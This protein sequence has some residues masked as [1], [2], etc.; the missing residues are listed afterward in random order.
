MLPENSDVRYQ[1]KPEELELYL[2]MIPPGHRLE[3][4][5]EVIDFQALLPEIQA[6]YCPDL[7]QPAV[8]P[9]I[10]FKLE[11]MKY[12][13]NLS[14]RS[15]L[16]RACTDVAFRYF[17]LIP[18]NCRLPH[19]TLLCRFRGR[20]GEDGYRRIFHRILK[21]ARQHGLVKD[22]LRLKDATHILANISI[23][24]TLGLVAQLR[25]RLI[26]EIEPLDPEAAEGF[27]ISAEQTRRQTQGQPDAIR[28]Q[29][30]V[31]LVQD[32][33]LFAREFCSQTPLP[34]AQQA[35]LAETLALA[36]KVLYQQAHPQTTHKTRSMV[37]PDAL[38]G[39]HGGY[40][41][42]YVLD[43][44]MDADS[45]L[46][47]AVNVLPAGGNEAESAVELIQQEHEHQGNQIEQLSIDGAGFN[48]RMIRQLEGPQSSVAE[49]SAESSGLGVT[50][51]VP[52][53]KDRSDVK[54]PASEFTPSADAQHVT[55]P[56]GAQSQYRQKDGDGVIY[57]FAAST[58]E[59]CPLRALCVS[60]FGKTPF[61]RSVRK[62]DYEAEYARVRERAQTEEFE[63]IRSRH[64]AIERKLNECAN[65]HGGRRACYW[66]RPKVAV[67]QLGIAMAVD[68]KRMIKLMTK[69]IGA[70]CPIGRRNIN[71]EA[72]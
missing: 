58:C 32:I 16:E 42:G 70:D 51:F 61:G 41:D 13:F 5:L 36:E 65:H 29:E 37:D 2:R 63:Q 62:N 64:P 50:V 7:G 24:S 20:L 30:R 33:L 46:I 11:L 71:A 28:L 1:A 52:P 57:R 38:R 34:K 59:N 47:T 4:A 12:W 68:I 31:E 45:E 49:G 44:T 66:S 22:Q 43:V 67:Q 23:P 27:R 39:K 21:Q 40:Y 19:F 6:G 69:T 9:I 25:D 53:K 56:E 72:I 26:A 48:G 8:P 14:D 10:A 35:S 15:V 17:L 60:K 3:L 55:C 18:I 54:I